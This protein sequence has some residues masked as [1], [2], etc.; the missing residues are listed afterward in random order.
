MYMSVGEEFSNIDVGNSV[1]ILGG[2]VMQFASEILMDLFC[3]LEKYEK[4]IGFKVNAYFNKGANK[5]GNIADYFNANR[6]RRNQSVSK[7][8]G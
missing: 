7:S 4:D 6:G 8:L 2:T 1:Y 3:K 5:I